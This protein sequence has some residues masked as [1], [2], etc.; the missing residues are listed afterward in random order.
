MEKNNLVCVNIRSRSGKLVQTSGQ[1]TCREA[2]KDETRGI[3]TLKTQQLPTDQ[4][5]QP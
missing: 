3:H 1:P 5:E 2:G 4:L